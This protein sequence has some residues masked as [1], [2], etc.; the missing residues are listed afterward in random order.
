MDYYS[1]VVQENSKIYKLLGVTKS[2][3]IS[4]WKNTKGVSNWITFDELENT[5][6]ADH[7]TFSFKA[8]TSVTSDLLSFQFTLWIQAI[9]K[10]YHK[11]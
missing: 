2:N 7:F 4:N 10:L 3:Q 1:V 11:L 8:D 5:Q 9:K 6:K